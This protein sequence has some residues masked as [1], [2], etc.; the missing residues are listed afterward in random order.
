MANKIKEHGRRV[1]EDIYKSIIQYIGEHGYPPTNREIGQMV[2]LKST[3][4]VHH[5]LLIMKDD[6]MI[7]TDEDFGKPR[8][9]RVPGYKFVKVEADQDE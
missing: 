9:I 2:G 3:S 5:Q 1:R 4:T 6:G 8:A 7:E